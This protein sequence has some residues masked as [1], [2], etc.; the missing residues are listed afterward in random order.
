MIRVIREIGNFAA[1]PTK[2]TNTGEI[3]E[4]EVGEAEW[5]LETLEGLFDHYFV[6][7][8]L[9]KKRIADLNVKLEAA[10]KQPLPSSDE[11][12]GE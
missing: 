10:G 2:N 9:N 11:G 4:V 1:H 5:L 6:L 3:V 12:E 7:P 8:E